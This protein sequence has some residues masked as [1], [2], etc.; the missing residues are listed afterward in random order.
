MNRTKIEK[1]LIKIVA[2][3]LIL[4]YSSGLYSQEDDGLFDR[5]GVDP[6]PAP[7]DDFIYPM[8]IIAVLFSFFVFYRMKKDSECS[9]T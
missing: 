3:L 1:Q 9:K 7:I 8:F 2:L 4:L 6:P 5:D